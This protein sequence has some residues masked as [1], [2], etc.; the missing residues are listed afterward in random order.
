MTDLIDVWDGAF[1]GNLASVPSSVQA[2][3]GYVSG[4]DAYHIWDPDDALA[5]VNSHRRFWAID[6]PPQRAF[7]A[8]DGITAAN[9]MH[10]ALSAYPVDKYTPCFMDIEYDAYTQN[11]QGAIDAA[12]AFTMRMFQLNHTRAFGYLPAEAGIDWGSRYT[13]QRPASLPTGMV[14][15]QYENDKYAHK[16]WDA[17][18]FDARLFSTPDSDGW[19]LSDM[20]Y[21]VIIRRLANNKIYRLN[22][23]D[24]T[25]NHLPNPAAVSACEADLRAANIPFT[26]DSVNDISAYTEVGT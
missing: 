8:Q 6:V 11:K 15:L 17:S 22:L 18:V 4:P 23:L 3:I 26:T 13:Y 7:V 21:A 2:I 1:L 5:V 9:R 20:N 19:S 25:C 10:A 24:G 16:G 14:G 12:H